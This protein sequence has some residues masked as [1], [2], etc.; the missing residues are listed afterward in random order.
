MC[1]ESWILNEGGKSSAS[2]RELTRNYGYRANRF[3]D[4]VCAKCTYN[5]L[6]RQILLNSSKKVVHVFNKLTERLLTSLGFSFQWI[7][8]INCNCHCYW[9]FKIRNVFE[10]FHEHFSIITIQYKCV[11]SGIN[12]QIA[13]NIVVDFFYTILITVW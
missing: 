3:L 4:T 12:R 8:L 5:S 7:L 1:S 2:L 6:L 13:L 11:N 10:T 9:T